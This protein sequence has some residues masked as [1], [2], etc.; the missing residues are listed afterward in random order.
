MTTPSPIAPAQGSEPP[1]SAGAS[2]L[3][4]VIS[5][6]YL[7]KELIGEGGMGA[8]Y[9]AEHTHMRKRVALKLLHAEM[10]NNE[11][12]L[13][14][15]R[16]EAEAAAHVEHPNIVAATD[17]GQTD[18]GAFFLVLEFVDGVSLRRRLADG[19]LDTARALHIGRQIALALEC[20]HE[21][22]IVHRDLKPEN[23]MLVA[24]DGDPDFVKVL[25]FGVARFDRP[26]GATAE[27]LTQAGT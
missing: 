2:R 25:D 23:V 12:V 21:A 6:R 9:L 7:I 19:P 27:L 14:R 11:E 22:G 26:S 16:R 5:G 17:F 1:A 8:V 15:F 3:G 24:K 13:A 4:Q 10:S 18:D 20:A